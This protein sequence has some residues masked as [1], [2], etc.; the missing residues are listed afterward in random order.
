MTNYEILNDLQ[1]STSVALIGH[2]SPDADALCSM[3][4]FRNFL[5][6]KY[7]IENIDLFAECEKLNYACQQILDNE[8]INPQQKE[9]YDYVITLDTSNPK[10]LGKYDTILFN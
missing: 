3:V 10:L 7:K 6:H 8:T 2:S 4:V 5:K 1:N 9:K